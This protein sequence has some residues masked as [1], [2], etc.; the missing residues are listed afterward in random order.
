MASLIKIN[1][2]VESAIHAHSNK[3]KKLHT[4]PKGTDYFPSNKIDL[5]IKIVT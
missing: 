4:I 3:L 5:M 1:N 2:I